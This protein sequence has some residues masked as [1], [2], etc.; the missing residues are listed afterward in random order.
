MGFSFSKFIG[1]ATKKEIALDRKILS[2]LA[3]ENPETFARVAKEV[4]A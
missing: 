2:T 3:Q 4:M 1:A